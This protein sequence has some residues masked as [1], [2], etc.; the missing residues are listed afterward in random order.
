[1]SQSIHFAAF[2]FKN[3]F[4]KDNTFLC[5]G[6]STK[7]WGPN[8]KSQIQLL[9]LIELGLYKTR[10]NHSF[11]PA[12]GMLLAWGFERQIRLFWEGQILNIYL[13]LYLNLPKLTM[14]NLT[15]GNLLHPTSG[16]ERVFFFLVY[17]HAALRLSAML[18][19]HTLHQAHAHFKTFVFGDTLFLIWPYQIEIFCLVVSG[20]NFIFNLCYG[21]ILINYFQ[22]FYLFFNIR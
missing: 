3:I 14:P 10:Q 12:L 6:L 17:L 11:L 1:M 4:E 15:S 19:P 21:S 8:C 5:Q 7:W 20:L 9:K 22:C 18:H 13:I 16:K 2:K